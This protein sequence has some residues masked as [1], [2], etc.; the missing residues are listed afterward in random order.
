MG[1]PQI[2]RF[3]QNLCHASVD[4]NDVL[5][6]RVV[7]EVGDKNALI[8]VPITHT[9]YVIKGGGNIRYLSRPDT[10]PVFEDKKEVKLWKKGYSVD[11][12]YVPID[13][14]VII[15]W[16]TPDR[17]AYRDEAS[18]KVVNVG[19]RGSFRVSIGNP[20]QFFR[21]VVG[22]KK[23]FDRDKFQE[24]FSPEVVNE[25]TDCFLRAVNELDLTYDQFAANKKAIGER[26]EKML[27]N[28]FDTSWG[29]KIS[30]FI[31]EWCDIEDDD[32][33]AVEEAAAEAQRQKK[34]KEYLAE[35]ER[36]DDKQWERDK[37]LRELELADRN[38]YYEVLKVIGHPKTMRADGVPGGTPGQ[39]YC[40]ACGAAYAIGASFCAACGQSLKTSGKCPNCGRDN[41]QGSAFC[42]ACGTKLR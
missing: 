4:D 24:D 23:E 42:S 25:F 1:K 8:E 12:I 38:A 40:P 35:L 13:C 34:I 33:E 29:V 20:E 15:K 19:A 11:V 28:S 7:G 5:F 32:K 6:V 37:Y 21:R 31:I 18:N 2:I 26:V 27:A 16:G 22:A 39:A 30:H 17:I 41:P 3:E 36:L 9:A 14:K 10:Y